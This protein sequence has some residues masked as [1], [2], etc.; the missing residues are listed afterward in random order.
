MTDVQ[1]GPKPGEIREI[2]EIAAMNVQKALSLPESSV[3]AIQKAMADEIQ[4]MSSHFTMAVADVQTTFEAEV[5]KIKA[6]FVWVQA[7]KAKIAVVSLIVFAVGYLAGS[8][9]HFV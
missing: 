9:V 7:N 6:D 4:I 1:A 3:K 8:I 5:L 2:G